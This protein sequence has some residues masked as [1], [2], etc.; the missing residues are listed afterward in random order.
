MDN[1]RMNYLNIGDLLYWVK[2]MK[3]AAE[4]TKLPEDVQSSTENK[5][6]SDG[7]PMIDTSHFTY[8]FLKGIPKDLRP[9]F[10]PKTEE[11]LDELEMRLVRYPKFQKERDHVMQLQKQFGLPLHPNMPLEKV[12]I[13]VR[14]EMLKREKKRK[15]RPPDDILPGDQSAL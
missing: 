10:T 9:L 8:S 14:I 7:R 2:L 13:Y 11:E 6:T 4:D 5:T 3:K 15:D 12:A 1:K